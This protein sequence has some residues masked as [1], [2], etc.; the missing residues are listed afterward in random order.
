MTLSKK[1]FS[2]VVIRRTIQLPVDET[3]ALRFWLRIHS[4]P[5][6]WRC[7]CWTGIYSKQP[8][9]CSIPGPHACTGLSSTSFPEFLFLKNQTRPI[10]HLSNQVPYSPHWGPGDLLVSI[11]YF[12]P[13]TW[14][15]KFSNVKGVKRETSFI[16]TIQRHNL[17]S[18]MKSK[19]SR[20]NMAK[21]REYESLRPWNHTVCSKPAIAAYALLE[22]K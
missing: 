16:Q 18:P 6:H 11:P 10:H 9:T 15:P 8:R 7:T 2:R 19:K 12:Q 22:Q 5:E 13:H 3:M 21:S 14:I 4:P 20:W 17:W 1:C